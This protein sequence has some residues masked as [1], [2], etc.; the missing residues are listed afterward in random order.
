M[1]QRIS[2][3]HDYSE[4]RSCSR[5]IKVIVPSKIHSNPPYL[6]LQF[7][8]WSPLRFHQSKVILAPGFYQSGPLTDTGLL[9]IIITHGLWMQ[10]VAFPI[11]SPVAMMA[12]FN[13]SG[14][15]W[16]SLTDKDGPMIPVTRNIIERIKIWTA[17]SCF[18][19]KMDTIFIVTPVI[20]LM[21]RKVEGK[22]CVIRLVFKSREILSK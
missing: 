10:L 20:W 2:Y 18:G 15:L 14:N 16:G 8:K 4:F 21:F 22:I 12:L 6:C 7:L 1:L 11:N 5:T 17:C 3:R 9:G 13:W 19:G